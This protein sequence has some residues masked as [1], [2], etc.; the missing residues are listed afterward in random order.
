MLKILV[1]CL[2]SFALVSKL[3]CAQDKTEVTFYTSMG[4]F[5]VEMYDA[6]RPITAGNFINLV[7]EKFYDGVIFHR[8]I[9]NFMI[10]GG[11]PTGTGSGGPG[12][13]ILDELSVPNLNV[14]KSIA[15]ARTS[16]PNSAG[17]QFYINLV[18]NSHLN[19]GYSV[20]GMVISNF[21][22]VQD[23]G[24]VPVNS[25][26][27]PLRDVVMDSLRVTYAAGIDD[28]PIKPIVSKLYQNY[29]NPFNPC[30]EIKFDLA[31][32]SHVKLSVFNASGEMVK[33]LANN[34]LSNGTHSYN[35]D[36]SNLNSGVYYYQLSVN[37]KVT[38]RKML[39]LK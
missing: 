18:N 37:N 13:T 35:F 8:V 17:S 38:I 36:G 26:D 31:K 30:T 22:V 19:A 23:I 7:N 12:Y 32:S 21:S 34:T 10:Q 25:N 9:N 16:A 20:F 24:L 11:D 27:R 3:A 4:T 15:M 2:L 33:I 39:F 5:V 14:Q 1:T 6:H 28:A 29:P